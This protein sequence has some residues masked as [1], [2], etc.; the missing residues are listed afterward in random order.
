MK[1]KPTTVFSEINQPR[2]GE[3]LMSKPVTLA[4][5]L[6]MDSTSCSEVPELNDRLATDAPT[7]RVP[8]GNWAWA[9]VPE[10]KA[11]EASKTRGNNLIKS[12]I[13]R[14]QM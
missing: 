4:V 10:R 8:F 14:K 7:I 11:I 3:R 6:P 13:G 5:V 2:E 12:K 9:E 1:V